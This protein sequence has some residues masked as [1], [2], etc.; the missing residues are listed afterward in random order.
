V[1]R[2]PAGSDRAEGVTGRRD[3][4]GEPPGISIGQTTT[5]RACSPEQVRNAG[6]HRPLNGPQVVMKPSRLRRPPLFASTTSTS[7]WSIRTRRYRPTDAPRGR[8]PASVTLARAMRSALWGQTGRAGLTTAWYRHD[9]LPD[10]VDER[11]PVR[12]R[13]QPS[14][15]TTAFQSHPARQR[16]RTSPRAVISDGVWS[17]CAGQRR[18]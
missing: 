7:R 2:R 10:E 14:A 16:T 13:F 18:D 3:P 9:L 6:V 1:L 15:A 4:F 11:T 5:T 8:T 12:R 17:P